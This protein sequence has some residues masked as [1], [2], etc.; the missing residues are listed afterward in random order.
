MGDAAAL[1]SD[2]TA[3]MSGDLRFGDLIT[4]YDP[5][6]Q[7]YVTARLQKK[8]Q[9]MVEQLE[10]PNKCHMFTSPPDP[11]DCVF[12]VTPKLFYAEQ[13]YYDSLLFRAD[14]ID[15]EKFLI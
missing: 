4:I 1:A 3:K 5:E 8:C 7:G 2:P 12:K 11:M 15:P 9:V 13:A 10:F 14:E 6:N